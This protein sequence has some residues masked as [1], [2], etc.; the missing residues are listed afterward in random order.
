MVN[1]QHLEDLVGFFGVVIL[2]DT[3]SVHPEMADLASEIPARVSPLDPN[4]VP[5]GAQGALGTRLSNL[6]CA[7]S[8]P[9]NG[10]LFLL[11][12]PMLVDGAISVS[13]WV[14]VVARFADIRDPLTRRP[15]GSAGATPWLRWTGNYLQLAPDRRCGDCVIRYVLWRY[16]GPSGS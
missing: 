11:R 16:D 10:A 15:L 14:M 1:I 9:D 13:N 8:G 4:Q 6:L 2:I 5:C 7:D 12:R 3:N